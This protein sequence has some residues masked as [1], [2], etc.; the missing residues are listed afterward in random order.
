MA[1]PK[2]QANPT[3]D[4]TQPVPGSVVAPG[5]LQTPAPVTPSPAQPVPAPVAQTP[6]VP[7]VVSPSARTSAPETALAGPTS[8]DSEQPSLPDPVTA[9]PD[10][11]DE[12][13]D[14]EDESD[15]GASDDQSVSWRASE[16][17]AHEKTAGWYILLSAGSVLFAGAVFFLTRD[18]V[19]VAVVIIA[20]L[21]LGVYGSHK[22]RQL[23]YIVDGH[24]I[25][26]GQ[27]YYAYD[28]FR[29]FSVASDGAFSSLVFM[30][31]KRFAL[32]LTVYYAPDD[33]DRIL[34]ILSDRL[35]LEAH[36]QDAVDSLMK[37]IRF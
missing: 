29:S 10:E 18:F 13:D 8:E 14:D 7:A 19:S 22:P 31:L 35:P 6:A 26:I 2:D 32:P 16:F 21:L 27:K 12:I 15:D 5:S 1:E 11:T 24:G 36:R 28:E 4:A 9:L 37:R 20:G 34:G 25:G 30:P 3:G 33:E 17:V 23:E